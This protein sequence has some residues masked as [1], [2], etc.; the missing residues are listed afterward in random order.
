MSNKVELGKTGLKVFPVGL[1][2]NKISDA[3]PDTN[4]EYGGK[5]VL[6]AVNKGLNFIDTAYLYGYGKS[7][8]IIGQTLKENKLRKD[9][10]IATKG[11]HDIQENGEVVFNNHPAF[12]REQVEL[13]LRRLQTDYIDL[14][15]IHFPDENTPKDEAVGELSRLKEEGKIRSIGVSNFSLE[16]LKEANKDGHVD[17]VQDEY[18]LI[19]QSAE[20]SFFPYFREQEISFIPYFPFSSG[21][22]AGKYNKETKLTE[23][24][25]SRPQFQGETYLELLDKVDQ[26][27]PLSEKYNTGLQNI[28]LAYYLSKDVVD[29]VI[30]GARNIKQMTENL[31]AASVPLTEEELQFIEEVFPSSYR[32]K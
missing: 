21:L 29:A 28:V 31:E 24:Q 1:G 13:S 25:L 18:S 27:R 11:A 5:I 8:E 3:N 15:Y 30:P 10:I 6:E 9:V 32:L 12:L 22:L 16:Q 14:Y 2:A 23:R 20:E 7:E 26:I 4:T 19:N 17:V